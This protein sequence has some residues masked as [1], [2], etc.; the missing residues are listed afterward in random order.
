MADLL[1][2]RLAAAIAAVAPRVDAQNWARILAPGMRSDGISTPRRAAMFLG[3]VAEETGG[4][5]RFEEDLDYRPERLVVVWHARFPTLAS[6]LP[7][8]HAP[9]RLANHVYAGRGGN[10][11][12]ASGDGWRFRGGGGLQVTFRDAYTLLAA[13][14]GRAPQDAADWARGAPE[15]AAF[16][17]CWAWSTQFR[18]LN[19]LADA[20]DIAGVTRVING[21]LTNLDTRTVLSNG[22]LRVLQDDGAP[23]SHA[24]ADLCA[25]DL[26]ALVEEGASFPLKP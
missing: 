3:Q 8:A 7:Y 24:P 19:A 23:A 6:A 25:D 16:A 11:D 5:T 4:L 15:G 13:A 14:C 22:A 17:A 12:E 18:G 20:W 1:D 26:N 9:E 21:G 2:Q 10:G